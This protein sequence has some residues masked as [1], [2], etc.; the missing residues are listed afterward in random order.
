MHSYRSNFQNEEIHLR[1][2]EEVIP[3][4]EE[5]LDV[6]DLATLAKVFICRDVSIKYVLINSMMAYKRGYSVQNQ[7]GGLKVLDCTYDLVNYLE[8]N[9]ETIAFK[10]KKVLDLGCGPGILGIYALLKGAS[11]VFQDYNKEVLVYST[12]PNVILN[13]EEEQIDQRTKSSKFYSGE[14]LSFDRELEESEKFD[15]IL[16]SETLSNLKNH[17]KLIALLEHR[18][19][20]EGMIFIA[21]K[22]YYLGVGGGARHFES[23]I[24]NSCLKSEIIW[25]TSDK[26]ERE[27]LKLKKS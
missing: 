2:Y 3:E 16:T 17:N 20:D 13:M 14:W 4:L 10:N 12:I 7:K 23:A 1:Y 27:I 18:L 24:K 22:S 5:I 26:T 25:K 19:K 9:K 6:K 8:E 15:I 21:A 11:V